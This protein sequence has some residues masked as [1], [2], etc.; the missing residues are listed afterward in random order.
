MATK[1]EE[2]RIVIGD[3]RAITEKDAPPKI[4]GHAAKFDSLSEDLGGFRERIAP[5]AFAKALTSSDIRALW[6]H[7]P[8]IVLGRNKA[9]TLRL[10]EDSAGLFYECDV[11]DTQLVRDMVMAPIA[12]GDVNQCSFGFS[13]KADKWA[14]VDGGWIRT[15]LEVD[16]FDVSPVTY[17][18]YQSTD[19]AVRGLQ[20]AQKAL[21]PPDD[22][23]VGILRRRLALS[24]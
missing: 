4:A 12:R 10:V 5:G 19:V 6:N 11:P 3:L 8:N 7:D 14:K 16:L 18:A 13:T 20:E 9:G 1:S 2:R 15:L 17:P 22:W 24:L 21:I 23:T